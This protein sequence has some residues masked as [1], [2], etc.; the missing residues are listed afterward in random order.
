MQIS[1]ESVSLVSLYCYEMGGAL[2][3]CGRAN[4]Q[5]RAAGLDN[6]R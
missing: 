2:E 6:D 1:A 5:Q 4:G 3:Q